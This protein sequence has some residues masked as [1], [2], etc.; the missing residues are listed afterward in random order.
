MF[1]FILD[2]A[3]S[4]YTVIL[5]RLHRIFCGLVLRRWLQYK[6]RYVES[7]YLFP[8]RE[9]GGHIQVSNFESNF[10]KYLIRSGLNEQFTPHCLRN[11]FAKRCLMSGMDIY[12]LSKLLGHSSVCSKTK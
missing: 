2:F 10:K 12:T 4:I 5:C 8:V 3:A 9:R 1:S 11:N 6:D 7:D